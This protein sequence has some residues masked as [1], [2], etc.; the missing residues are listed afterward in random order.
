MLSTPRG[1][2]YNDRG[3]PSN[4]RTPN[5]SVPSS[6]PFD[7]GGS[8]RAPSPRIKVAHAM[9]RAQTDAESLNKQTTPRSAAIPTRPLLSASYYA[10]DT[11]GELPDAAFSKSITHGERIVPVLHLPE[12]RARSSTSASSRS[13]A[14][15]QMDKLQFHGSEPQVDDDVEEVVFSFLTRSIFYTT[16]AP[17][18]KSCRR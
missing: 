16:V 6:T 11:R 13:S 15:L 9:P 8:G 5:T 1:D 14:R 4:S 18:M 17:L 2:L 7:S 12:A 10:R 3:T